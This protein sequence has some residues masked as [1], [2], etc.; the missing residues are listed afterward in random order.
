M[1]QVPSLTDTEAARPE[2]STSLYY[3]YTE[4]FEKHKLIVPRTPEPVCPV[5]QRSDGGVKPLVLRQEA[6]PALD[7]PPIMIMSETTDYQSTQSTHVASSELRSSHESGEE[8]CGCGSD[9]TPNICKKPIPETLLRSK[10]GHLPA[11]KAIGENFDD[12]RSRQ[13][14][15]MMNG[16]HDIPAKEDRDPHKLSSNQVASMPL[17]EMSP[18]NI[19]LISATKTV[20]LANTWAGESQIIRDAAAKRAS[21]SSRSRLRGSLDPGLVE[22]AA[23]FASFDR[24]ARSPF[25]KAGDDT[26]VSTKESKEVDDNADVTS[27][28][29][30]GATDVAA[31]CRKHQRNLANFVTGDSAKPTAK[32]IRSG[33]KEKAKTSQRS[34]VRTLLGSHRI[35]P[36]IS[37]SQLMKPL[38]PLPDEATC[39][40]SETQVRVIVKESKSTGIPRLKLRGK[41]ARKSADIPLATEA[42]ATYGDKSPKPSVNPASPGKRLRLTRARLGTGSPKSDTI[43]RSP[44]LKQCNALA[45]FQHCTRKDLFSPQTNLTET[46][47]PPK[48]HLA[49]EIHTTGLNEEYLRSLSQPSDQ[50]DLAYPTGPEEAGDSP[51]EAETGI[52]NKAREVPQCQVKDFGGIRQ[53]LSM[54]QLHIAGKRLAT[55][56]RSL[57]ANPL[58]R[59]TSMSS[60]SLGIKERKSGEV[61]AEYG[62]S[63]AT[64]R[65]GQRVKRWADNAR[66]AV[67]WYVKKAL[68]RKSRS[69]SEETEA[70][71]S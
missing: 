6:E 54:L 58:F 22:F 12:T 21:E 18:S 24:L 40:S 63:N 48:D 31:F 59:K 57:D 49:F 2:P 64:N 33:E 28:F 66:K 35:R 5:P 39:K 60:T 10:H 7:A 25:S 51:G 71:T 55:Y 67:R 4:G 46:F 8:S 56:G 15:T 1:Y 11:Q 26:Y 47:I 32:A 70:N 34:A 14:K 44:A 53:K 17:D 61:E 29:N 42:P 62:A 16:E 43:V 36:K 27:E 3:D 52:N 19:Q 9:L 23:I 69:V 30:S 38:P 41:K 50:F 37:F 65:H 45:E 13:A 20:N 68:D